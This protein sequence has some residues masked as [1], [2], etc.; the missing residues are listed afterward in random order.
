VVQTQTTPTE[1]KMV[2]YNNEDGEFSLIDAREEIDHTLDGWKVLCSATSVDD[3]YNV[4]N[5]AIDIDEMLIGN[6][7]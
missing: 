5:R 2:E 7:N 6:Q 4:I 1:Y 3:G